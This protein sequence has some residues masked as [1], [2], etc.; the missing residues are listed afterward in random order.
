M[1]EVLANPPLPAQKIA[2]LMQEDPTLRQVYNTVQKVRI[3]D[4]T[5]D[6]LKPFC[7]KDAE[8]SALRG[9]LLWGPRVAI[10]MV[11]QPAILKL[12][13]AGHRHVVATKAVACSYVWWPAIDQEIERTAAECIQCQ[14]SR[15]DEGR[16]PLPI[17]E[18]PSRP[19]Q[20]LHLDIAGLLEGRMFLVVVDAYTEWLEVRCIPNATSATV[21]LQFRRL[22]ATFG[23]P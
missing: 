2:S 5:A 9:C 12:I 21:I 6:T 20:M 19:W 17:W 15:R 22:F 3:R 4:L 10:P 8:L 11:V 7:K 14:Q 1:T 23:I 16:A 18:H 13:H